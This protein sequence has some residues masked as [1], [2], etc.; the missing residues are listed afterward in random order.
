RSRSAARQRKVP[1]KEEGAD[2]S[3]VLSTSFP[4]LPVPKGWERQA[5]A[6]GWD[7]GTGPNN[8]TE[9]TDLSASRR[10][11]VLEDGIT[12]LQAALEVVRESRDALRRECQEVRRREESGRQET[13]RLRLQCL[14]LQEAA[15]D[16]HRRLGDIRSDFAVAETETKKVREELQRVRE[17]LRHE[18]EERTKCIE[19][20]ATQEGKISSLQREREEGRRRL[21]AAEQQ[22]ESL[23]RSLRLLTER[24]ENS[25]LAREEESTGDARRKNE[26]A[27][28]VL[29]EQFTVM[30]RELRRAVEERDHF[31]AKYHS[32]QEAL[33]AAQHHEQQV[34]AQLEKEARALPSASMAVLSKNSVP[35]FST[36]KGVL[37]SS[38]GQGQ[39]EAHQKRERAQEEVMRLQKEL[40]AAVHLRDLHAKRCDVFKEK[41]SSQTDQMREMQL[42][43]EQLCSRVDELGRA[44]G[45]KEVSLTTERQLTAQLRER[46]EDL[47]KEIAELRRKRRLS[48]ADARDGQKILRETES[49]LH[50]TRRQLQEVLKE[51]EALREEV[52]Q[53][54]E[55]LHLAT[56]GM[57]D[58]DQKLQQVEKEVAQNR[59]QTE[60]AEAEKEMVKSLERQNT[61]L[62]EELNN[63]V[64]L[65]GVLEEKLHGLEQVLEKHKE[66][67][68]LHLQREAEEAKMREDLRRQKERAEHVLQQKETELNDAEQRLQLLQSEKTALQRSSEE[69]D[70]RLQHLQEEVEEVLRQKA[71]ALQAQESRETELQEKVRETEEFKSR[72]EDGPDKGLLLREI[73]RREGDVHKLE[74]QLQTLILLVKDREIKLKHLQGERDTLVGQ[75]EELRDMLNEKEVRLRRVQEETRAISS[76]ADALRRGHEEFQAAVESLQ[77]LLS[78][79]ESELER[80]QEE[81]IQLQ[82]ELG[83]KEG[84]LCHVQDEARTLPA[85]LVEI[86]RSYD[87]LQKSHLELQRAVSERNEEFARLQTETS[88]RTTKEKKLRELLTAKDEELRL[89]EEKFSETRSAELEAISRRLVALEAKYKA[90]QESQIERER[91]SA[92]QQKELLAAREEAKT[93]KE[94]LT[95]KDTELERT[96]NDLS[97][98]PSLA[99]EL[100]A[101]DEEAR[102]LLE[103]LGHGDERLRSAEQQAEAAASKLKETA[104]RCERLEKECHDLQGALQELETQRENTLGELHASHKEIQRLK[105]E[106]TQVRQ[107]REKAKP[108]LTKE[109]VEAVE[110]LGVTEQARREAEQA[111]LE[112]ERGFQVLERRLKE[113]EDQRKAA[114]EARAR[115]LDRL[116]AELKEQKD[117]HDRIL[118]ELKEKQELCGVLQKKLQE[119]LSQRGAAEE[120]HDRILSAL[121]EQEHISR[122][123]EKQ[124]RETN[125]WWR[126]GL[127][128]A[129]ASLQAAVAI[130]LPVASENNVVADTGGAEGE[131]TVKPVSE[132]EDSS[133]SPQQNPPE[134]ISVGADRGST[135]VD[136]LIA[137][138]EQLR[139]ERKAVA[140]AL[141]AR[142]D[143]IEATRSTL[144]NTAE[145]V[146]E[147]QEALRRADTIRREAVEQE[148][149][150]ALQLGR[151]RAE[152]AAAQADISERR[153]TISRLHEKL[154][155]GNKRCRSLE[156]QFQAFLEEKRALAVTAGIV[157]ERAIEAAMAEKEREIQRLEVEVT[158]LRA[159]AAVYKTE[160]EAREEDLKAVADRVQ[161]MISEREQAVAESSKV[162]REKR[163]LEHW[164]LQAEA[165]ESHLQAEC[166]KLRRAIDELA[167]QQA[168]AQSTCG[169]LEEEKKELETRIL[170]ISKE[171]D[172]VQKEKEQADDLARQLREQIRELEAS[173]DQKEK[174]VREEEGRTRALESKCGELQKNLNSLRTT[175]T[176][177]GEAEKK[178]KELEELLRLEKSK[179][180]VL[181]EDIKLRAQAA[182]RQNHVRELDME[183]KIRQLEE[184]H[185]RAESQRAREVDE[186]RRRIQDE[187]SQLRKLQDELERARENLEE[188]KRQSDTEKRREVSLWEKDSASPTQTLQPQK[189]Q[190][191]TERV[192]GQHQESEY[193]ALM[194]ELRSKEAQY[195]G[196][197]ESLRNQE[198]KVN[199]ENSRLRRRLNLLEDQLDSAQGAI[200]EL[201]AAVAATEERRAEEE[202]KAAQRSLKEAAD[203]R[204]R[205]EKKRRYLKEKLEETEG[206]LSRQRELN[207]ATESKLQ[208]L[209]ATMGEIQRTLRK[210]EE[211]LASTI[212]TVRGRDSQLARVEK[213]MAVLRRAAT[214]AETN[215][216][217]L[218]E[219]KRELEQKNAALTEQLKEQRE[220]MQRRD[221]DRDSS[222]LRERLKASQRA[223]EEKQRRV[224]LEVELREL[225]ERC[226]ELEQERRQRM[227]L[228]QREQPSRQELTAES[229][230]WRQESDRAVTEDSVVPSASPHTLD[231]RDAE[232]LRLKTSLSG[233]SRENE[234]I[235]LSLKRAES[236]IA[237]LREELAT[238][239]YQIAQLE[240]HLE[241]K[242]QRC[243]LH[244]CQGDGGENET[245]GRHKEGQVVGE[246]ETKQTERAAR[247]AAARVKTL[248]QRVH[249]ASIRE[250]KLRRELEDSNRRTKRLQRAL[251]EA[252][253]TC[254]D[255][256][257]SH[258]EAKRL[259]S[260]ERRNL[261][262]T[263][264]EA[265]EEGKELAVLKEACTALE[266]E[267]AVFQR[268]LDRQAVDLSA[269]QA[270]VLRLT[271]HNEQLQAELVKQTDAASAVTPLQ[272]EVAQLQDELAMREEASREVSKDLEVYRLK[273]RELETEVADLWRQI[274]GE[275]EE[276]EKLEDANV[277]LASH[278]NA[279]QKLRYAGVLKKQLSAER[280]AR[281]R[282]QREF[283]KLRVE[284]F[285]LRPLVRLLAG[286]SLSPGVAFGGG[287][288]EPRLET[289]GKSGLAGSVSIMAASKD[290]ASVILAASRG[291]R[292]AGSSR[293]GFRRPSA[294]HRPPARLPRF[295][296]RSLSLSVR[297]L[298][299]SVSSSRPCPPPLDIRA[300]DSVS[301]ASAATQLR[302]LHRSFS[303]VIAQFTG[304]LALLQD[305][306]QDD[307]LVEHL[308]SAL[309]AFTPLPPTRPLPPWPDSASQ[310]FGH[311]GAPRLAADVDSGDDAPP[312]L[313]LSQLELPPSSPAVPSYAAA[314]G[315]WHQVSLPGGNGE[316]WAA[317]L[318]ETERKQFFSR[319]SE[320]KAELRKKLRE[321]TSVAC[322][323][324]SSLT[325][326]LPA[327]CSSP[328]L[329]SQLP[330]ERGRPRGDSAS[331]GRNKAPTLV[332][333]RE[334]SSPL[335]LRNAVQT[336]AL[337]PE[338]SRGSVCVLSSSLGGPPSH[339][340]VG[341]P[342][343]NPGSIAVKRR[344]AR[345][346]PEQ[347]RTAQEAGRMD[348]S[349][350]SLQGIKEAEEA[351]PRHH[352]LA[353]NQETNGK[354]TSLSF[355][356]GDREDSPDRQPGARIRR[357][358]PRSSLSLSPST[359]P[360][361]SVLRLSPRRLSLFVG[362]GGVATPTRRQELAG[363]RTDNR[364]RSLSDPQLGDSSAFSQY[365]QDGLG[366]ASRRSLAETSTYSSCASSLSSSRFPSPENTW[367]GC[368]EAA[369][370]A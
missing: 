164:T 71:Q 310:R 77:D 303:F 287:E 80:L 109:Q 284:T 288:V 296:G 66:Q 292:S 218:A 180:R 321:R 349:S 165:R 68:Q 242:T 211:E 330:F 237:R 125:R 326:G 261:L 279:G 329:R 227:V 115:E 328:L 220:A 72:L 241:E 152:L 157:S 302:V 327:A 363:D 74:T 104:R 324:P 352:G 45:F 9:D 128:R 319:L 368:G 351:H 186:E 10:S 98:V 181:E 17:E 266:R 238:K 94:L 35:G 233:M 240:K 84:Q 119:L 132:R 18:R 357:F 345:S 106:L 159:Q 231:S 201:K 341:K 369:K 283:N 44:H 206:E 36:G 150:Q 97:A 12:R 59:R 192:V 39:Q 113:T 213:E 344:T 1:G 224:T 137:Q 65:N 25:S 230:E 347:L 273:T 229:Q 112:A 305:V 122:D 234:D 127:Q 258:E 194:Q 293:I 189:G 144:D 175:E 93:L 50:S 56:L 149:H 270:K 43:I 155:E 37:C 210:R 207:A 162:A 166:F 343:R 251:D 102:R 95:A 209:Q 269:L 312:G 282:L 47:E 226:E 286:E 34:R 232:I 111:R 110:T 340:G 85:K 51:R 339:K 15:R 197:I 163:Q 142:E 320:V 262:E 38:E 118:D 79:R 190:T 57:Q 100:Q 168:L 107:R 248:E 55:E 294:R 281:L 173:I 331:D 362:E 76:E 67:I 14:K 364:N 299:R 179:V 255:I 334:S 139:K 196:E 148:E 359:T 307:G 333:N 141:R 86:Q 256:K 184:E 275:R 355:L 13:D 83:R 61:A 90:L 358:E 253:N 46:C 249:A 332:G 167:E 58:K 40:D 252:L 263:M 315:F 31:R 295:L 136:E 361:S 335:P 174:K 215:L 134:A 178:A 250:E 103:Q 306:L 26:V 133:I 205:L 182:D 264:K 120:A 138:L 176:R 316:E 304:V 147:L 318:A 191:E 3:G 244:D 223:E 317:A 123:L 280:L 298:G 161:Q 7:S 52:L 96:R 22:R 285:S 323:V 6:G 21:E 64:K 11:V 126:E 8:Q 354:K 208:A 322:R 140:R 289:V 54:E 129:H 346:A 87:T 2:D 202:E 200:G 101:K 193:N 204:L 365:R 199:E 246:G 78:Q 153:K 145:H 32:T 300:R 41:L 19:Q 367:N 247:E 29:E 291:R 108:S 73:E 183:D 16:M 154:Q 4:L 146:K 356:S 99:K 42:E 236:G 348:T 92:R 116:E 217:K 203:A 214:D 311:T 360:E 198:S 278:G 212:A 222:M 337:S 228:T 62:R 313:S 254:E 267:N 24:E 350:S 308:A 259:W 195:R 20:V 221:E 271:D 216:A 91:Q 366:E 342:V 188:R 60:E 53:K 225:R 48:E 314:L 114:V 276:K 131:L 239:Q 245:G 353:G 243:S 171:K 325:Q 338:S 187:W 105:D 151:V 81:Q 33:H 88:Q 70:K 28:Q 290:T 63:R 121:R 370:E 124:L 301:P 297:S 143:E 309:P 130:P 257:N 265:D 89:A 135:L 156:E 69:R 274:A 49:A 170:E 75:A 272:R 158:E 23:M 260:V 268:E 117:S 177:R 172:A 5:A 219:A 277:L 169:G 336:N 82:E 30:D 235:R 160:K 27:F 185:R